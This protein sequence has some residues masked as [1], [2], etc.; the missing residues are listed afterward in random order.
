MKMHQNA[1][2]QTEKKFSGKIL[3]KLRPL[4]ERASHSHCHAVVVT[5]I[6]CAQLLVETYKCWQ[7][8][9]SHLGLAVLLRVPI[10]FKTVYRL[11]S[12]IRH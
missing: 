6:T 1:P 10:N 2:L 7:Q 8:K 4:V 9:G 5:S 12:E 11:H 3:S